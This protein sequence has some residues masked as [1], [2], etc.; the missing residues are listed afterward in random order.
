[1]QP[2]AYC[3]DK[4]KCPKLY[5]YMYLLTSTL[6]LHGDVS[7]TPIPLIWV[8]VIFQLLFLNFLF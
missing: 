1:M 3:S 5:K 2:L 7:I 8:L 4:R 6:R